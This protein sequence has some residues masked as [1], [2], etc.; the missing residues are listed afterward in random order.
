MEGITSAEIVGAVL[1]LLPGFLT[2][3][4]FYGLTPHPK[5]GQFER[6]VQAL[7]FT[8]II[9]AI[10]LVIRWGLL[11]L[12]RVCAFGEW[13]TDVAFVY[14]MG[15]AVILGLV[16]AKFANNDTVHRFFR[17]TKWLKKVKLDGITTK[18]SYASEWYSAFRQDKRWVVLHLTDGR[19]LLGW[20][21]EWPDQP[22]SGH[23]LIMEP[24]WL[25]PDNSQAPMDR[26]EKMIVAAK[27]VKMVECLKFTEEITAHKKQLDET[28][29]KLVALQKAASD[30]IDKAGDGEQEEA[31]GGTQ[32]EESDEE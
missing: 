7:I 16:V 2:A 4:F 11:L 10:V 30:E 24:V 19:R 31:S 28:E 17:D 32:K 22:D 26:V 5:S 13:T 1:A 27:D 6:V 21:C 9:H 20:P 29:K 25:L 8:G 14:S 23:F 18:T 12:G 15:V 3:W